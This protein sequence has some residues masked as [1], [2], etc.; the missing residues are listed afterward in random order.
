MA[1]M[2]SR[3]GGAT[4]V[5]G[6]ALFTAAAPM[7][8]AQPADEH[9]YTDSAARCDD[10]QTVV[11]YGRTSRALV[12]ICVSPD[13][14]LEYR[15][16]RLSDQAALTMPA[17]RSTDGQ[18][19]ATNDGV[20]YAVTPQLLLVSEGDTVLYRGTWIE[21][22]EPRFSGSAASTTPT[23]STTT[24]ATTQA[25]PTPSTTTSS[26]PTSTTSPTATASTSPTSPTP[27][28]V[29]TTTVTLTPTTE[30]G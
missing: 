21:F 13:G 28:T 18:V 1:S 27:P 9:G 14:D 8:I 22:A 20:T 16:V 12:A 4:A 7:A 11:A 24:S 26:E 2:I 6:V 17:T 15:G 30:A 3:L 19:T 10:D 23:T 25:T 29:S 5:L